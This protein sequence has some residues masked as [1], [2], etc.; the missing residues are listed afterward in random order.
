MQPPQSSGSGAGSQRAAVGPDAAR[1]RRKLCYSPLP[2]PRCAHP[3]PPAGEG[4]EMSKRVILY[5]ALLLVFGT[6]TLAMLRWGARL[7]P[8]VALPGAESPAAWG[9]GA[10]ASPPNP[11]RQGATSPA[12]LAANFKHPQSILFL[13]LIVII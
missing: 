1:R 6:G 3:T 8:A 7:H 4:V 2:S 13:Q 11:T 9:A 10:A 5:M 12:S